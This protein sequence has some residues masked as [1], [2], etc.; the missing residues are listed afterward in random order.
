MR[1]GNASGGS[2]L[3]GGLDAG[4]ALSRWRNGAPSPGAWATESRRA[5]PTSSPA[6]ALYSWRVCSSPPWSPPPR[7]PP[8]RSELPTR[9]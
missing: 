9:N 8:A 2:L 5:T 1:R 3:T 4:G 6:R 7:T